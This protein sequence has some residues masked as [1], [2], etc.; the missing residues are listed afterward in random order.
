LHGHKGADA[1][2]EAL[3]VVVQAGRLV[4]VR[5]FQHEGSEVMVVGEHRGSLGESLESIVGVDAGVHRGKVL[6]ESISEILPVWG[7]SDPIHA[8]VIL[9]PPEGSLILEEG[10]G[11]LDLVLASHWGQFTEL[12]HLEDP[13]IQGLGPLAS[14]WGRSV[15]FDAWG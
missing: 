15:G 7:I 3:D 14:E 5:E 8:L 9:P 6:L 13:G 12:L 11:K 2:L 10:G 1:V 4:H